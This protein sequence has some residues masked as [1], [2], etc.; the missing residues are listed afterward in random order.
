MDDNHTK[1]G[2]QALELISAEAKAKPKAASDEALNALFSAPLWHE[3]LE[4]AREEV[5]AA[6]L[7]RAAARDRLSSSIPLAEYEFYEDCAK[8]S[9]T[10]PNK[11]S[12]FEQFMQARCYSTTSGSA[13]SPLSFTPLALDVVGMLAREFLEEIVVG[14]LEK[15]G[16]GG[17][18][19]KALEPIDILMYLKGMSSP[20]VPPQPVP[21]TSISSTTRS[22]PS[23]SITP[24]TSTSAI[25]TPASILT[26]PTTPI[27]IS[28]STTTT[29]TT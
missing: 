29:T 23:T 5:R 2:V 11:R 13:P 17:S 8:A 14:A 20:S 16:K 18:V 22:P 19:R 9:F 1:I 7:A 6:K 27:S 15:R 21:S 10:K 26:T 24:T 3:R 4:R 28:T 25:S 12:K